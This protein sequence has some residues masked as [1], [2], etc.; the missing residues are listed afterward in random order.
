MTNDELME[1]AKRIAAGD[2]TSFGRLEYQA[3]IRMLL[4][5]LTLTP[6]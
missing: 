3:I 4:A 1:K 2:P 6:P 5:M